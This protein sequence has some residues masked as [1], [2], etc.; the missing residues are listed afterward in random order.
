MLVKWRFLL[1]VR[2]GG[3]LAPD[4]GWQ[5]PL[6]LALPLEDMPAPIE[7]PTATEDIERFGR[8]ARGGAAPSPEPIPKRM[9]ARGG[10]APLLESIPKRMPRPAQ[11][12]SNL[13]SSM[14]QQSQT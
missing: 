1:Q 9:P 12:C 14:Q 10:V 4:G 11:A 13:T 5:A 6:N 8:P 3:G 7:R 2:G